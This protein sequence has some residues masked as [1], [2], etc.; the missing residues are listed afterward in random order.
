MGHVFFQ[1]F[2]ITPQDNQLS[3]DEIKYNTNC[4]IFEIANNWPFIRCLMDKYRNNVLKQVDPL[5]RDWFNFIITN[6]VNVE[7]YGKDSS[8]F[9]QE[10]IKK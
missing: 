2:G 9:I 8:T 1:E 3:S 6:Q 4:V 7:K 10:Y 5:E